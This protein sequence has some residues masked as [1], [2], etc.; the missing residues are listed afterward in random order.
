[1]IESQNKA[2]KCADSLSFLCFWLRINILMLTLKLRPAIAGCLVGSCR[3]LGS[4][5]ETVG[6]AIAGR[7]FRVSKDTKSIRQKQVFP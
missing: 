5:I 1:M 4:H 6:P 7:S 2:E 3:L